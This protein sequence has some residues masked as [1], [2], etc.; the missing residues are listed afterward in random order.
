MQQKEE[1]ETQRDVL[2]AQ[3]NEIT[4]SIN[5]A[6][7][8]QSAVL[9]HPS[10]MD[11]VMP[12]YF[13]LYKPRDI[14]SGD[15]YWIKEVKNYLIVVAADCTGHGVPGAFMS[16]L[17]ITLLN[18][19]VGKSRFDKP[20]EILNRLRK[21]VKET[22][23]QEGKMEEQKDGMD[24][25][26]AIINKEN[27][28]LQ[29]A[30]A[31]NPLYLVRNKQNLKEGE[32]EEKPTLESEGFKLIEFKGDRQ[33]ISVHFEEKD[34]TT[35]EVQLKTGDTIYLFSDGYVDQVGGP[36]RKKYLSKRFKLSLLNIQSNSMK[37]QHKFLDKT[38]EE[39][40]KGYDQIDDILVMGIRV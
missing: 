17:G 23:A 36:K 29:Y 1:I 27:L 25:A 8:I 37:E 18:E 20:G 28:E 16:M 2:F 4:D 31:F 24:M 9:P 26:L 3:K 12:E 30:G 7:R 33:P 15:F 11:K 14:V 6:Q 22:L 35:H 19:Q 5:Y 40:S 38:L 32:Y 13:V 10:Y 39:W 34:F 21:K